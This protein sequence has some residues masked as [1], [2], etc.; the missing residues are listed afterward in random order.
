MVGYC[1][2]VSRNVTRYWTYISSIEVLESNSN[3]NRVV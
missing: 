3:I 1:L 2:Q